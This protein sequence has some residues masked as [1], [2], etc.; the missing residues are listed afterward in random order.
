VYLGYVINGG[1]LK[2]DPAKMEAIM[3]WP[4][5]PNVTEVMRRFFG[6]TQYLKI[7][8]ASFSMVV[9]PLCTITTSSESF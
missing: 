3:E 6:K 5:P 2:I 1:E 7:F 9:A 4:V 8:I